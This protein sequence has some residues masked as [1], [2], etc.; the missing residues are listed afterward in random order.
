MSV[1]KNNNKNNYF[2]NCLI[3]RDEAIS[4][5]K[6]I[7]KKYQT[8]FSGE[9][10]NLTKYPGNYTGL[11]ESIY[12]K[13]RTVI[14]EKTII[15]LLLSKQNSCE[16]FRF[17]YSVLNTFYMYAYGINRDEYLSNGKSYFDPNRE[18]FNNEFQ[19][20]KYSKY[21]YI[22][23]IH[24]FSQFYF[25][26][27]DE[28]LPDEE[29]QFLLLSAV[30]YGHASFHC[31]IEKLLDDKSTISLLY[32]FAKI[33]GGLQLKWRAGYLMS[34]FS[35]PVLRSFFSKIH[36]DDSKFQDAVVQ[37][38]VIEYLENMRISEPSYRLYT[39]QV[40]YQINNKDIF[41]YNHDF[42]F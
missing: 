2:G 28:T 29:N 14:S 39:S 25:I 41:D 21:N 37:H 34:L 16:C 5:S 30:Y 18:L 31:Y 26:G 10:I 32:E 22:P 8:L 7:I 24:N 27:I 6:D 42:S 3:Y 38:K 40:L 12:E 1:L 15:K 35:G 23:T 19:L 17:H 36:D 13:T 11:K 20:W 9:T 4:I 33:N